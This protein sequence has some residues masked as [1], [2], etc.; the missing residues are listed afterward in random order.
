MPIFVFFT[1]AGSAVFFSTGV[2]KGGT[3]KLIKLRMRSL[4]HG[5]FE[6]GPSS[7]LSLLALSG[8]KTF[9]T[10]SAKEGYNMSLVSFPFLRQKIDMHRCN[11]NVNEHVL[12]N[13]GLE[14]L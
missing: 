5:C 14:A 9:P 10:Y 4:H 7:Y 11:A 6:H 2:K 13:M 1:F 3:A 12:K 8:V